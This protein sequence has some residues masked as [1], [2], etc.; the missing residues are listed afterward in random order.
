M[1]SIYYEEL[2]L[3]LKPVCKKRFAVPAKKC[4]KGMK[5]GLA[6]FHIVGEPVP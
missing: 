5:Y 3:N 2:K 4:M 6:F 1:K